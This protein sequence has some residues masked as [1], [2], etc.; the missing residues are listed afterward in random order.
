MRVQSICRLNRYRS[1]LLERMRF[2]RFVERS[3]DGFLVLDDRDQI[4]YANAK[5]RAL[6]DL[7]SDETHPIMDSF[8]NSV[9]RCYQCEPAEVWADWTTDCT[10]PQRVP[11][12]RWSGRPPLPAGRPGWRWT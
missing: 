12:C 1:L 9:T 7:P 6:L 3:S 5:A 4:R 8:L 10:S 11:V 2:W